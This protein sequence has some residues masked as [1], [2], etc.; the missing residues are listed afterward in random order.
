MKQIK[1]SLFLKILVYI[2]NLLF[3][4]N[5]LIVPQNIFWINNIIPFFAVLIN[6]M[7][8][9]Y[10]LKNNLLAIKLFWIYYLIILWWFDLIFSFLNNGLLNNF[11]TLDVN[12]SNYF[13]IIPY[14]LFL[15]LIILNLFFLNK[16]IKKWIEIVNKKLITNKNQTNN[17]II[18]NIIIIIFLL[19]FKFWYYWIEK[20][21]QKIDSSFFVTKYQDINMEDKD[22]LYIDLKKFE[23][24]ELFKY[25]ELREF[26]NIKLD[27]VS[28]LYENKC[29]NKSYYKYLIAKAEWETNYK[30]KM[31]KILAKPKTEK[32]KLEFLKHKKW[33]D[34]VKQW[35]VITDKKE[36]FYV[37]VFL[38]KNIDILYKFNNNDFFNKLID[39]LIQNL[40]NKKYYK[41][42][43]TEKIIFTDFIQFNRE[44]KYKVLYYINNNNEDKSIE[45]LQAQINTLFTILK[46]DSSLIE[47]LV[48]MTCLKMWFENIDLII[49]NYELSNN[50][51][52]ILLSLLDKEIN[53]SSLNNSLKNEHKFA[54]QYIKKLSSNTTLYDFD[55][56]NKWFEEIVFNR[57][58]NK[59]VISNSLLE[60]YK[61]LNFFKKNI[62]GQV[63][64]QWNIDTS[65]ESQYKKLWD[66]NNFRKEIIKKIRNN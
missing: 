42:N 50:S 12:K 43:I 11:L 54:L 26:K 3:L 30:E 37:K 66:L 46:W 16:N 49:E 44:L 31:G 45:I 65:Y 36:I 9:Y 7:L 13:F 17:F 8:F 40:S 56:T 48:A 39:E 20:N 18:W 38:R 63:L 55:Y 53:F 41:Y 23:Y 47:T 22:N 15:I 21:I 14:F 24:K 64:W 58:N 60:K 25:K 27:M 52:N 2:I 1:V 61:K 4:V 29:Y 35:D 28:C 32:N 62:I 10:V 59:W 19:V 6:L 33:P 5:L 51:K 34:K 57:I